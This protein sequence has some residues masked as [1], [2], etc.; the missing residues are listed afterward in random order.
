[1]NCEQVRSEDIVERYILGEMDEDRRS[2]FEQHFFTCPSC[3]EELKLR[4]ALQAELA[5]HDQDVDAAPTKISR[6]KWFIPSSLA[7]SIIGIGFIVWALNTDPFGHSD[8][9]IDLSEISPPDYAP[10]TLRQSPDEAQQQF[11]IAMLAYNEG[12]WQEA[13]SGLEA[14]AVLDPVAPNISFF[15]GVSQLLTD[16]SFQ[17]VNTL[18]RTIAMGETPYLEEAYLYLAMAYLRQADA[19]AAQRELERVLEMNGALAG[20]ARPMIQLL[21]QR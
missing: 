13:M 5:E 6:R 9:L 8:A 17:A 11:R 20:E 21:K 4:Q 19:A 14:A 12:L 2:A 7:A 1:M 3:F 16:R 15:L 10:S 18:N